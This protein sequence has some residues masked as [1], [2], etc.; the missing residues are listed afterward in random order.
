MPEYEYRPEQDVF[1]SPDEVWQVYTALKNWAISH[2]PLQYD[3]MTV[4]KEEDSGLWVATG[5]L[6]HEAHLS[7][8]RTVQMVPRAT[9]VLGVS[10]H[11]GQVGIMYATPYL[12]VAD[13]QT[14]ETEVRLRMPSAEF[15]VHVPI[16]PGVTQRCYYF[17]DGSRNS[18]TGTIGDTPQRPGPWPDIG[19][20]PCEVL[21]EV[22][23]AWQNIA[24]AAGNP[25]QA[26][27]L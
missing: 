27:W 6:Y 22:V 3:G 11:V 19:R 7:G 5:P 4:R 20:V 25:V 8:K 21:L 24:D 18:M 10:A 13:T 15:T 17:E 14:A 16:V 1:A 26:T 12:E 9:T 23:S 2:A